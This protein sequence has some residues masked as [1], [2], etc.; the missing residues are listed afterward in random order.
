M[1]KN[2]S[3]KI[4]NIGSRASLGKHDRTVYAATKAGLIGMTRTW[5]LELAPFNINVN[6]IGPGL[7]ATELFRKVNPSGSERTERLVSAIPLKRVGD[8][9]DM[10]NVIAFFA[11]DEASFVTGQTL[12]V[13]GGLS[14]HSSHY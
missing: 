9:E 4:I 14:V 12:Y 11:S 7:I 10:A 1:K 2:K 8:P 13:C 3:G 6:Y 5:A